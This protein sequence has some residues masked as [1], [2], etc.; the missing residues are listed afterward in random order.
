VE[1]KV[2]LQTPNALAD[3][4]RTRDPQ[5]LAELY[6]RYGRLVYTV[7][8][9]VIPD[10]AV[11]ED[12]TQETFLY[13]WNRIAS[14]DPARGTL[15]HWIALVARSR[16]IDHLRS[17][18]FRVSRQSAPL[19]EA[20]TSAAPHDHQ[21]QRDLIHL[22]QQPWNRLKAHQRR[23]LHLAYYMGL[24][25]PEIAARLNRPLGTIK[26]WMRTGLQSMRADLETAGAR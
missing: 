14:Y 16:A 4:L 26:T 11:A 3:R 12:L 25:Q 18:E 9:A 22:L 17:R 7:A 2:E 19:D 5:A 13:V 15:A 10:S 21:E 8:F 23:A 1:T 20:Y 6:D 24:S